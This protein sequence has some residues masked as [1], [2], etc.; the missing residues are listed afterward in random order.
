MPNVHPIRA[1]KDNYIWL[2]SRPDTP[3]AVIVDPGDARPVL[4][5]LQERGLRLLAILITHHHRDHTGGI[6]TL[7]EHYPAPVYGPASETITA[8]TQPLTEQDKVSVPELGLDLQVLDV[9]GHTRGAI[10]FYGQEMLFCGD[11]LFTAGCGK[12][13]EGTAQQMHAS[14][15]KLAALP[16]H[17]QVYCGHE[18]TVDNLHFARLVEPDNPHIRARLVE[19]MALRACDLPSVPAPLDLERRSNPFLR[20]EVPAVIAAAERFAARR[21]QSGAEVFAV[22]RRW[23]DS[24]DG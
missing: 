9:P 13:F 4:E 17:T 3:Y 14:L 6:K 8:L 21:L 1:F 15:A 16:G 23:K 19:T 22:V 7:L 12:L 10:A 18:Y 5:T 20:C 2:I 24:L 11:T